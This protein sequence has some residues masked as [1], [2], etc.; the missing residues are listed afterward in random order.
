[1]SNELKEDEL[2]KIPKDGIDLKDFILQVASNNNWVFDLTKHSTAIVNAENI[3][4]NRVGTTLKELEDDR[5]LIKR[6]GGR[7]Y[8]VTTK[9]I[10]SF[11]SRSGTRSI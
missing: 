2:A 8:E 9:G 3:S 4:L 10:K 1:M 6:S 11:N 7:V 5:F